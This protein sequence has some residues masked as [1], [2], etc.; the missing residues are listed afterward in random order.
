MPCQEWVNTRGRT[1]TAPQ[2]W[3][4]FF[5]GT[6]AVERRRLL[7][8][9]LTSRPLALLMTPKAAIYEKPSPTA[10]EW[11]WWKLRDGIGP[12][13][14]WTTAS[15]RRRN[16]LW[17]WWNQ[18]HMLFCFWSLLTSLLRLVFPN[19]T[20]VCIQDLKKIKFSY[21][22]DTFLW[23]PRQWNLKLSLISYIF[24]SPYSFFVQMESRVPSELRE[25]F[26][27]EVLDHTLVLLTCGDY[28][29]GKSVEVLTNV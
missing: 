28:L 20:R 8:P 21:H 7:T 15:E 6:L 13:K 23:K 1:S 3:G 9:S 11:L 12:A 18:D 14:R 2:T 10:G 4:C 22:T 26:G 25:M 24:M 5:W 16:K 19:R 27:Q 17:L 29:M